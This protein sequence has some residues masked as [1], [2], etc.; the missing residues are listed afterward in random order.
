MKI[1]DIEIKSYLL[2]LDP[3]LMQHGILNRVNNSVPPLYR[4]IPMR[5]LP[6]LALA[7]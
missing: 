1:T 2:P 6:G 3:P 4:C 7:T 5:V